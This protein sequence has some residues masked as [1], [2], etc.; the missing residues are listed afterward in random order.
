MIIKLS[1]NNKFQKTPYHPNNLLFFLFSF[2]L[3]ILSKCQSD[4]SKNIAV[5]P[6]KTYFPISEEATPQGNEI[7]K[8]IRGKTYLETENTDKQKIQIVLMSDESSIYTRNNVSCIGS[9]EN[10]Y[11]PYE[12]NIGNMCSFN[13]K[14]SSTFSLYDCTHYFHS[15]ISNNCYTKEKLKIFSDTNLKKSEF[16]EIHLIHPTN[17][18]GICFFGS[19]EIV[20]TIDRKFNFIYQLKN[21]TN[22]KYSWT[23]KYTSADEGYYILGDIID[24]T[25][26]SFY[27]DNIEQNYYSD[28]MPSLTDQISWRLLMTKIYVNNDLY[29]M[30]DRNVIY[31]KLDFYSRYITVTNED[32]IEFKNI[33]YL[34]HNDSGCFDIKVENHFNGVYCDKKKYLTLTDNYKKLPTINFEGYL[35]IN[36]TF[37]PKDLFIEKDNKLYFLIAYDEK[38]DNWYFGNIFLQKYTVVFT[39]DLKKISVLKKINFVDDDNSS[40][41]TL[42]IVL[43]VVL[44]IILSGLIFG[45]IGV[46]YGKDF[47][48]KRRKKANELDDDGYDYV[49]KNDNGN[50]ENPI[51]ENGVN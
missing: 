48:L 7:N 47:Y 29:N 37:V 13:A 50:K 43:I 31:I 30:T 45:F 32:Y 38:R 20:N 41:N 33:F 39:N 15:K 3:I 46:K 11:K 14:N 42:K 51:L 4:G 17:E 44:C 28:V 27:N 34:N 2:V 5:I 9:D 24:N 49:Q 19:T 12:K 40:N 18:S 25:K 1:I 10:N 26:I 36:I 8:L 35:Q 6:F 23:L 22:S 21:L 16:Y